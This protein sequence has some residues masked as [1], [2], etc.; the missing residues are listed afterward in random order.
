MH[1]TF[2]WKYLVNELFF[3]AAWFTKLKETLAF[4]LN[5]FF[6]SHILFSICQCL[7]KLTLFC[8]DVF[9]ILQYILA[10]K[11]TKTIK[12]IFYK[13]S[14]LSI[15]LIFVFE[16]Y[17]YV[18]HRVAVH[19]GYRVQNN[20]KKIGKRC[21]TKSKA[22]STPKKQE[23]FTYLSTKYSYLNYSNKLFIYNIYILQ[24]HTQVKIRNSFK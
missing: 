2:F 11:K 24:N 16:R 19:E 10:T 22:M 15:L 18:K 21:K 23:H 17:V 6:T 20:N 4:S 14:Y 1:Y 5:S 7:K 13:R 8:R 9:S 12:Y 3:E